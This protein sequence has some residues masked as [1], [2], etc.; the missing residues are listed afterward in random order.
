LR[1]PTLSAHR[2]ARS[3]VFGLLAALSL[4]ASFGCAN[5]PFYAREHLADPVMVEEPDASE[6]HLRQKVLYSREG[7]IGGIGTGAGGGCGC[8]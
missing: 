4:L 7:A 6:T 3:L 8:Y 1:R 2:R 5:V